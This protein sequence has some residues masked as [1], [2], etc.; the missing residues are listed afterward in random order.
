MIS[1]LFNSFLVKFYFTH[2]CDFFSIRFMQMKQ[3]DESEEKRWNKESDVERERE[4]IIVW[5]RLRDDGVS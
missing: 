3:N 5:R 2:I 4:G 1:T